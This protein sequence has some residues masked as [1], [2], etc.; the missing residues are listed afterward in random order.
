MSHEGEI[1]RG[2]DGE[3][4]DTMCQCPVSSLCDRPTCDYMN[5]AQQLSIDRKLAEAIADAADEPN[6]C[7]LQEGISRIR[8]LLLKHCGLTETNTR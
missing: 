6:D 2:N 1:R 4:D 8:R 3:L 7:I 5:V